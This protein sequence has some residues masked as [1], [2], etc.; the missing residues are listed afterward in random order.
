[1]KKL[2]SFLSLITIVT[3]FLLPI[4][5]VFALGE[6]PPVETPPPTPPPA[7]VVDLCPNIDGAQ[8]S[9][10]TGMILDGSGNCVTP[11]PADTIAPIIS[12]V[13]DVSVSSVAQTITWLTNELS[14][15]TFEYGTTTGYGSSVAISGGLVLGGTAALTNLFPATT[16]YYCIHATDASNNTSN[17]CGHSFTTAASLDTTPPAVTLAAVTSLSATSATI[18]WTTAEPATSQVEYG[19]STNYGS[20]TTMDS[21]LSLTHDVVLSNLSASTVYHY[22]IK[23]ADESGNLTTTTDA[24]FTTASVSVQVSDTTP[25]IISDISTASVFSTA[26][27]IAWTTNELA[28]STLEYGITTNYGSSATLDTTAFLLHDATIL[29]LAPHTT[30]QYCIHATD[31]AGNVT[32]S[33][34]HSFTTAT[35]PITPD[36]TPPVISNITSLSL[37]TTDATIAWDTNEAA[38]STLEYG[39][40]TNYGSHATISASALLAHEVTLTGLGAGTTYD[41]CI[42]AT[43][44]SGN[45]RNSCGHSFT[46]A[47][48]VVQTDTT[49]PGITLVTVAPITITSATVNFT[50]NEVSNMQIAYGTTA[51]YSTTTSLD[52]NLA[53][54][55]T[56]T[57]SNLTPNTLYHYRIKTSDEVGNET[58]SSDETFT[59][60]ALSSSVVVGTPPDTTPPVISEVGNISLGITD[61][62]IGWTTNELAA[63]MFEYGTSTNYGSYVT[64][65]TSLLL[66]HTATLTGLTGGTT[67]YYCINATDLAGNIAVSCPHSFTT[68][69]V[70]APMDT[71]PPVISFVVAASI[72]TTDATVTWTT[73]EPAN[74]QIQYGTTTSY[75]SLTNLDPVLG[76]TH[77]VD[78]SGLTPGT[79]YHYRVK[80]ID[81]AGNISLGGD[82]TFTIQVVNVSIPS[83]TT[84]VMIS[85]IETA[86]VS[87]NSVTI[88]WNTDL[89]TDSQVEYGESENFGLVTEHDATLTTSHSVTVGGLSPNT[90]YIFRVK[91][92]VAGASIATVSENHEFNTLNIETPVVTPA[93]IISV[94]SGTPTSTGVSIAWTTDKAA[95]SQ[96]EYGIST[97]YGQSSTES[98]SMQTSHTV[99]LSDLTPS[100][101]YH[102]HVKSVDE[103]SNITYSEDYT[104]TT[105]AVL[106]NV[107]NNNS[108]TVATVVSAP[109]AI[110]TLT[111]GG[112]DQE[113]VNLVW[114]ASSASVDAAAQYDIRYSIAPITT[115]NWA[116]AT[117]AQTTP[118]YYVDLSPNGTERSYIVAGLNPSTTYY[119]ALVSKFENTSWSD[120]SNIVSATTT[121]NTS[122]NNETSTIVSGGGSSGVASGTSG[123]YGPSSGGNAK[124]SFEPT[125]IKAEPAD[126]EIVFSWKNPGE[127]D[128][129]RTIVVRKV[130]SYPSS[131]TDGTTIYEG[132]SE[133]FTDT[134]IQN[135]TTYYYAVYSYNH[136]K[137]Y[138]TGVK[139]SASPNGLNQEVKF[140][141]SGFTSATSTDHFTRVFK[142]GDIDIEIEHLQEI[143]AN[144]GY[145]QNIIDGKFGIL[146]ET[147]L[148]D[149]QNKHGLPQTGI[150]DTATQKEL[151]TVA[152]SEVKLD[153][154]QEYSVFDI[155]L[156]LGDKNDTVSALQQYLVYEGSL[157]AGAVDG[158]Y[159]QQ[160]K[161]AVMAFQKKYNLK[162]D[163]SVGPKTRHKMRQLSGL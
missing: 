161:T 55:H 100:T 52:T 43:D 4:A 70:S 124:S 15:S 109:A 103:A 148:K 104:F 113:S 158:S 99:A 45:V 73:N 33:C 92:K 149:F 159:G 89:P 134:N 57:L 25:P 150:V 123:G 82:K 97:A 84:N 87:T 102:Y 112:Y 2:K 72:T 119:F 120:L 93:N 62:T 105:G 68:T 40:T 136:N 91:S 98:L 12:A 88:N 142:K 66:T 83:V 17:S 11:P 122:V 118:I 65:P 79:T 86:S 54:S 64:L 18:T 26:V 144:H 36:V 24:T 163:G 3:F 80:S 121:H 128:F 151:N 145:P 67:Y 60:E 31:I 81:D 59:T 101:L 9:I 107:G 115:S 127:S 117:E 141:E 35:A 14:T 71:T 53:L 140:N 143:L 153:I 135:G 51:Q 16:Y 69:A 106:V 58:I 29:G 114:H 110:I 132:R 5:P 13:V 154:P 95:T 34:G 131:P 61:A 156:K 22:R 152:Q 30:Y 7:P 77:S 1:M 48:Q 116:Q 44:I 125:L 108:Q 10:P 96:V 74:S 42:H 27:T 32:N 46:T 23:S 139:V 47:T 50:T 19:T 111:V 90:N 160:T 126:G 137:T 130:G 8:A 39:T 20:S 162:P 155:N 6:L 94:S 41:Y 133:T 85:G 146:T 157:G 78:I 28:T 37:G 56:D 147:A 75:G 49:P 138:S 63:S 21:S 129:V 76:L 38:I